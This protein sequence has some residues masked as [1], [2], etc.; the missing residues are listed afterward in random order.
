MKADGL[1]RQP[2]F[3]SLFLHLLLLVFLAVLFRG[4]DR[5]YEEIPVE[6]TEFIRKLGEPTA[7]GPKTERK[8]A[9]VEKPK[10]TEGGAP[11]TSTAATQSSVSGGS[12]DGDP[13]AEDFE[14]SEMPLLL[15]E[16][17]VPYPTD[18]R[19]RGIQGNV[20]FDILISSDGR[21]RDLRVVSSPDPSLTSAAEGAVR[22]F[23]FRPARMG[24]KP[25]AIRLRYTYRFL[26]Q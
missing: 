9:P 6:I 12:P 18:A 13:L 22:A 5:F 15:N 11:A 20:V 3:R 19:A 2:L 1:I 10:T 8:A 16:V 26:L 25:V 7:G 21:V 4:R 17:R 23:K 24:D 14:V